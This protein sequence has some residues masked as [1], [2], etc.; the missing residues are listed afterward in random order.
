[1]RE[2]AGGPVGGYVTF[3][4]VGRLLRLWGVAFMP[5]TLL[6]QAEASRDLARRARRLA[7]E[8]T[9]D[10]DKARLLR[11]ADELDAQAADL[12]QRA[13]GRR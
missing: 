11:H 7:D 5:T 10:A 13:A 8:M 9:S 12:E 1:M 3:L 2:P 4:T 6:Q